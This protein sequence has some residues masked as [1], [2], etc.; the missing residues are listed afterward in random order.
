MA[1]RRSARTIVVNWL[2]LERPLFTLGPRRS[3]RKSLAFQ[4]INRPAAGSTGAWQSR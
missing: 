2:T 3:R 4:M 1:A